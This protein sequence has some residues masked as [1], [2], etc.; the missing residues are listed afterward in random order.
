MSCLAA[1]LVGLTAIG[2][3]NSSPP[4]FSISPF[5]FAASRILIGSH[6]E[7]SS[8]T[9]IDGSTASQ[10]AARASAANRCVQIIGVNVHIHTSKRQQAKSEGYQAGFNVRSQ[11]LT[12]G[13]PTSHDPQ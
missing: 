10:L 6:S 7:G 8:A 9:D 3:R 2:L 11:P 13:S 5:I 1:S 12:A 4:Y